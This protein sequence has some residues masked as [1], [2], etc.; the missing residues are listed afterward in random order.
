MSVVVIGSNSF[1][2]SNFLYH[3]LLKHPDEDVY[4]ISRS[5]ES[6]LARYMHINHENALFFQYDLNNDISNIMN[7]IRMQKPEIIYN[8]ACNSEVGP[9]WEKPDEWF[10]TNCVSLSKL[11]NFLKDE[12]Y[13]KKFIHISS[14]EIYGNHYDHEETTEYYHPSTPYAL[15]RATGDQFLEMLLKHF[16]FPVIFNRTCNIYGPMQQLHKL[17]PRAIYCILNT[18]KL[19]LTGG[20]IVQR[21]YLY[22]DDAVKGTEIS[23]KYG[24]S[25]D[26]FHIGTKSFQIKEIIGIICNLMDYD[27]NTLVEVTEERRG[28]DFIYNLNSSKMHNLGWKP[29]VTI[30][31]GL[32]KTIDWYTEYY[33]KKQ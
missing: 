2:G 9:S 8:F 12:D 31:E 15:S 21:G 28:S 18:Q 26:I 32:Q 23:T 16:N 27:Y 30:E 5:P 3:Y 11:C 33:A 1:Y 22:I 25:G 17:I 10:M 19:Q 20:G 14:P 29:K 4:C 24:K 13:L 6:K 7:L